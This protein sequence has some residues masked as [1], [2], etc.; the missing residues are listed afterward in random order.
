[1][2]SSVTTLFQKVERLDNRSLDTFT[3]REVMNQLGIANKQ[4]I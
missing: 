3:V 1:M 4:N 2:T